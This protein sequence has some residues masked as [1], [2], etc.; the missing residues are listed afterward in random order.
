MSNWT[1]ERLAAKRAEYERRKHAGLCVACAATLQEDDGVRCVEC[2]AEVRE[3]R[4][5][6][7]RFVVRAKKAAKQC[8]DC[9]RQAAEGR[10]RCD[11]HR[12]K[13]QAS[14]AASRRRRLAG[15]TPIRIEQAPKPEPTRYYVAID[16]LE[17]RTGVRLLR[18]AVRFDWVT[19]VDLFDALGIDEDAD[20]LEREAFAAA[21]SRFAK[22]GEL[23]RRGKRN[24]Y[25]YRV[26]AKG[27]EFL[28]RQF[29]RVA[30]CA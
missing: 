26:T 29:A 25:E 1:P 4:V 11:E 8:L 5:R 23:D 12:T 27:R 9:N 30:R 20:S 15:V 7:R 22:G 16:E 3:S 21:L 6:W 2:D 13:N 28:D 24:A 18:A 10:L 17:G 14:A 19:C